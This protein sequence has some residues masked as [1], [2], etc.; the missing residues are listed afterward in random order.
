VGEQLTDDSF[1]VL[2]LLLLQMIQPT[3]SHT[4]TTKPTAKATPIIPTPEPSQKGD[5]SS[6]SSTSGCMI[7]TLVKCILNC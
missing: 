7:Q 3:N 5:M 1:I 2:L 6:E 4:E